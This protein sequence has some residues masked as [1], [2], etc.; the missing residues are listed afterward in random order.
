MWRFCGGLFVGVYCFWDCRSPVPTSPKKAAPELLKNMDGI[1]YVKTEVQRFRRNLWMT[2][3]FVKIT[4]VD[5]GS[6]YVHLSYER[7]LMK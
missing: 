4:K 3:V 7:S 5:K 2:V 6:C 1:L